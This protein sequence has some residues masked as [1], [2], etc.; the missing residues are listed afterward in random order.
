MINGEKKGS[1]LYVLEILKR[2]TDKNHSLTY[3]QILEKLENEYDLAIDRK[4]VARDIDILSSFGY[5]IIKRGNYGVYLGFRDF[6]EGQLR[7]LVDAIYS[8]RS[9]PTQYARELVKQLTKDHSIY[10]RRKFQHLEKIDD[11]VRSD[12]R[13]LFLTIELLE[14]AISGG[15][16]VE[17]QYNAYGTNKKLK[18]KKD[19]KIYKINPYYMVN[20]H[21][22]YYLV[23][24]YDK[25][26]NLG[27][28]KIEFI[29]DLKILDEPVKPL[30]SLPG[31]EN[32]SIKDYIKEHIY[33]NAG[34]SVEAKIKIDDEGKVSDIISWFGNRVG[35]FFEND[36][37]YASI[38]VNENS[39]IY[40]ALQYGQSVE[41][42]EP[43]STREKILNI[44]DKMVEKY[45]N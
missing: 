26:D 7:F 9:M 39:L 21:G 5:E 2:Y 29:S 12:S 14:D 19:G 45:K 30:S 13:Q 16:K 15:K 31:Q 35:I 34:E 42:V 17:F 22:N 20:T 6:E 44:L 18:P 4:T 23:C 25:Y 28:Y 8:S 1:I 43:A 11:D 10:D 41:V 37:L 38:R 36:K 24:N 40:W 32:F 33:M 27:N 3:S